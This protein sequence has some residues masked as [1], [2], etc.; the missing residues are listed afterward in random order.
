MATDDTPNEAQPVEDATQAPAPEEP[1]GDDTDSASRFEAEMD[2]YPLR[3]PSEDPGWAVKMVW[4]W[5]GLCSFAT[6]FILWL[7]VMSFFYD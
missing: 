2:V 1:C 7:L 6:L 4:T 5:V 3:D